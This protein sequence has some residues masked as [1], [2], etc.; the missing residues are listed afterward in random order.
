VKIGY[1]CINRSI[2]C[3]GDKTFR[4][5]S[6]SDE[7]LRQTATNNLTCLER[8]LAYNRE[9]GF[10]FFRIS[11][12]L[13]PFASHPVCTLDW[14][15]EFRS[16]FQSLGKTIRE[17]SFRISMHP[18]QFTLLNAL[19]PEIVRRSIA[20]LDYHVD[21]LELLELDVT[22]KIQIHAGGI[23]G[24]KPSAI[25]RLISTIKALPTRIRERLVIENDDR[26]F[27]LRDVLQVHDI[28]AVP[29]L[30]DTFHH[31]LLNHGE[32]LPDAFRQAARTWQAKDGVPM[33]DYSSQQTG[34]RVGRHSETIDIED[35]KRTVTAMNGLD[36][37][38][39]LE[40]KD[41]EISAARALAVLP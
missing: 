39:M 16:L 10:G 24:D 23:Y 41:K 15:K 11:S 29:I 36:L 28:T 27:S 38:I 2:A 19:N 3:Q 26:L 8:V 14:K 6:Y 35:F 17:N 5:Q 13:I 9:N 25:Q 7:R 31:H 18:D 12:Q 21:V 37:D 33:V 32:T 1:P 34:M 22:A 30:F 40:I 4:L 20:E